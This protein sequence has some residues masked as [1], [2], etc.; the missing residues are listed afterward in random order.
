MCENRR[1]VTRE[2]EKSS[3]NVTWWHFHRWQ[4]WKM[5]LKR[6][7]S[8]SFYWNMNV[9]LSIIIIFVII[10]FSFF[11]LEMRDFEVFIIRIFFPL[12]SLS[13]LEVREHM[14]WNY[15][16]II[17]IN[18]NNLQII[19]HNYFYHL[20]HMQIEFDLNSSAEEEEKILCCK[21]I[22]F[23]FKHTLERQRVIYVVSL[24]Y[25]TSLSSFINLSSTYGAEIV[26]SEFHHCT[27]QC[28]KLSLTQRMWFQWLFNYNL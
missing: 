8:P 16:R 23:Q 22:R 20:Y 19:W 14:L 11:R 17:G 4:C 10:L 13:Q 21:F 18:F 28:R 26:T 12:F 3:S 15:I 6:K 5:S 1:F 2:E 7:N 27:T 9:M 25:A 24:W